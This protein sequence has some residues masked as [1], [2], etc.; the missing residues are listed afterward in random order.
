MLLA[1]AQ[2]ASTWAAVISISTLLATFVRLTRH[3]RNEAID[4]W[5]QIA[6]SETARKESL[7]ADLEEMLQRERISIAAIA[8]LTEENKSLRAENARLRRHLPDK[9][10]TQ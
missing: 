7:E 3:Q 4:Q 5:R 1:D 10:D 9:G 6:A 2:E 8:R